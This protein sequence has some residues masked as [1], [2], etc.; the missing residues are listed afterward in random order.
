MGKFNWNHP[1]YFASKITDTMLSHGAEHSVRTH[2]IRLNRDALTP[3]ST[4]IRSAR[5][6]S[7]PSLPSPRRDPF[8][9]T[10]E[11][12]RLSDWPEKWIILP[13]TM[14]F[15]VW[16]QM[17]SSVPHCWCLTNHTQK[18]HLELYDKI[19][20]IHWTVAFSNSVPRR[21]YLKFQLRLKQNHL[22]LRSEKRSEYFY[23]LLINPLV[24]IPW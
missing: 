19:R 10:V 13:L 14:T 9:S 18:Y 24:F 12:R 16:D 21:G 2:Q 15:R 3:E 17:A 20:S 11:N 1:S 23:R 22:R 7:Q 8:N 6:L 5:R 4:P